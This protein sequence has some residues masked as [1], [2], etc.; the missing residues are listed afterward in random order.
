MAAKQ[1][2][3]NDSLF[4]VIGNIPGHF[5]SHNLRTFFSQFIEKRGFTCFHFKHRPEH[6]KHHATSSSHSNDRPLQ[7]QACNDPREG[8]LG[9]GC[10]VSESKSSQVLERE[11]VQT[12]SLDETTT[13]NT[14]TCS[15]SKSTTE[16]A[17]GPVLRAS[18]CCCVVAVDKTMAD[19]LKSYDGKNW[20]VPGGRSLRQRVKIVSIATPWQR[21]MNM[22][23]IMIIR[24]YFQ[25]S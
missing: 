20:C 18:T 8:P 19:Q 4:F 5:R 7:T 16:D 13:K 11:V 17:N 25:F 22:A 1:T 15:E 10:G 3:F 23:L 24:V 9:S 12:A 14:A 21:G 6:H 2:F